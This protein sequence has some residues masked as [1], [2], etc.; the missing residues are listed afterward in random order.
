MDPPIRLISGRQLA[1]LFGRLHPAT[2]ED[3]ARHLARQK[4]PFS[5][6]RI[7]ALALAPAK[8]RRHLLCAFLLLLLYLATRSHA[9]L[10]SCLLSFALALL[11]G[12]ESCR[13]FR[14]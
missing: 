6:Q 1:L 3:I 9:A 5:W 12:K 10:I 2:D 14:L 4:K 11:C 7:R 8:L 13:R